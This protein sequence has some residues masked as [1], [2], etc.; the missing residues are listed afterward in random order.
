MGQDDMYAC[1]TLGAWRTSIPVDRLCLS[2]GFKMTVSHTCLGSPHLPPGHA[3]CWGGPGVKCLFSPLS[4][5]LCPPP[6]PPSPFP[7][8]CVSFYVVLDFTIPSLLVQK[9]EE[10]TEQTSQGLGAQPESP[11]VGHL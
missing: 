11:E 3:V 9:M 2:L 1:S 4:S 5:L 7:G 8:I 10:V 6:F